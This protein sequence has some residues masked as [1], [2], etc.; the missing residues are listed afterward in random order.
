MKLYSIYSNNGFIDIT[1]PSDSNIQVD[2][3]GA[4]IYSDIDFNVLSDKE[5]GNKQIMRLK[6][7]NGNAKMRLDAGLG[8]IYLRKK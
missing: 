7:K 1:L 2:A 6:L 8:N 3:Q 4:A 5:E